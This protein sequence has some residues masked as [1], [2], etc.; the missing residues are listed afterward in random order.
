MMRVL[1]EIQK[2]RFYLSIFVLRLKSEDQFLII[3]F[4][5]QNKDRKSGFVKTLKKCSLK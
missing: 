5:I 3:C 1:R 2:M 4:N